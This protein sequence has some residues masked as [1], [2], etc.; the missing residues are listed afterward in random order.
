MQSRSFPLLAAALALSA[1]AHADVKLVQTTQAGGELLKAGKARAPKAGAA[2]PESTTTTLYF[3]GNKVR[4]ETKDRVTLFDGTRLLLLNAAKKSYQAIPMDSAAA[5]PMA[6]MMDIKADVSLKPGTKTKTIL[7]KSAKQYLLTITMNL[8]VK[9]GMLPPKEDGTKA[10]LPKIPPM[11]SKSEIWAVEFPGVSAKSTSAMERLASLPGLK[12]IQE[13]LQQIKGLG[14]E[15]TMT[16]DLMGRT[17]TLRTTTTSLSEATLPA[18]LFE[19]P[20]GWKQV[21]FDPPSMPGGFGMP[22]R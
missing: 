22:G 4:T 5:N 15:T 13:K 3:K 12:G 11:T 7:G 10:E 6:A 18:S 9:P 19:I 2:I 21:P 8:G 20:K 17:M 16:Q 14:L 1:A